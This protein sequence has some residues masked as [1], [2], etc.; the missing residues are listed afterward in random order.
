[1]AQ[2][3]VDRVKGVDVDPG[4]VAAVRRKESRWNSPT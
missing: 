1:M 2:D 3:V 4:M